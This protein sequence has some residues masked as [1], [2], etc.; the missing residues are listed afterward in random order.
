VNIFATSPCPVE[1]ARF[2]DDKR[3]IKM[4]LESAQLLSTAITL[5]GGEGPYRITHQNHPCSVWARSTRSNYLWLFDHFVAL[6]DE[7]EARYNRLHKCEELSQVFYE[8]ADKILD[9]DMTPFMNCTPHKSTP[10]HE[11]YIK[12]LREKW[13]VDKRTPTHYGRK[14]WAHL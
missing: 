1:S 14:T 12:T 4:I 2:L 5:T 3:V 7:Y 10:V 8:S 13:A 9:G 6:C 11:A